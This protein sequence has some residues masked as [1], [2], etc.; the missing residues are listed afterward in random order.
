MAAREQACDQFVD[1]S[2]L[3]DDEGPDGGAEL[4]DGLGDGREVGGGSERVGIVKEMVSLAGGMG[5]LAGGMGSL[6]GDMGS[7]V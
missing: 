3:P 1:Q 2:V 5:S 7:L 4:L 6:S